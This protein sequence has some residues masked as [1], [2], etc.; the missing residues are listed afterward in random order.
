MSD[1][2]DSTVTYTAVSIP[3]GG[4]SDIGSLGVNG[5]P[6]M[7]ED[8][9][10]Y[11]V[12][13]FQA[14][15]SPD[16]VL[17]PKYPPSLE[18]VPEHVYL[19]FMPSED[20]ILPAEKQPLSA[21]VSPTDE[22]SDDDEDDDDVDIKEDEDEDEEEEEHLAPVDSTVVALPAV[23]HAPPVEETESFEIDESAATPPSHPAYPG[24]TRMSIRPQTPISFPSDIEIARLNNTAM[25][26][27]SGGVTRLQALVEKKRIVITE[28]VVREILQL[29]DAEGVDCLPN[30]EIFAG[31]AR[32]GYEKPSTKLTFY[33]AFFSTQWKFFIHTILHSLSAKKTLWNEFSSAL[34]YLSSEAEAQVPTQGDDV[35]EHAAEEVA[36]DIVPPTPSSP[37]PSSPVIPSSPPHQSPCPPQPQDVEGLHPTSQSQ[38]KLC[39]KLNGAN[40]LG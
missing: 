35:Q 25:V 28:E 18:Y 21:A 1:S 17:G 33:K 30:D 9:Y 3:F 39:N 26:K 23:D 37:S 4:L 13:V 10:A 20:E 19:E 36:T 2:E 29:N 5:P 22:S 31:L 16:Y 34:I 15:S 24:T 40:G 11:V 6:V 27:R 14:P 7:P 8:P 38:F 32:M 12:A